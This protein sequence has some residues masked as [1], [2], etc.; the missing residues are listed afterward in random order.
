LASDDA[1]NLL[2]NI[3]QQTA[4]VQAMDITAEVLEVFHRQPKDGRISRRAFHLRMK[5]KL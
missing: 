1:A 4:M 5:N 2:L 3:Q